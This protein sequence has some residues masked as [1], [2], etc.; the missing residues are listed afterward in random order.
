M[1][2][3]ATPWTAASQAPPSIGFSRWGYWSGLP[4]LSPEDLPNSGI[5]L[6][7]STLQAEALPL[8]HQGSPEGYYRDTRP[9]WTRYGPSFSA[10]GFLPIVLG[11]QIQ[12]CKFSGRPNLGK[13]LVKTLRQKLRGLRNRPK[14]RP[15]LLK[16]PYPHLQYTLAWYSLEMQSS[17]TTAGF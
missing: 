17:H 7:S 5:K 3:S 16:R 15:F 6:R 9:E 1:S 10:L 11:T 13:T 14:Y 4:F 12:S 2:D 8:S